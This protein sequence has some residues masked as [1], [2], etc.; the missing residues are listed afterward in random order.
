MVIGVPLPKA[1]TQCKFLDRFKSVDLALLMRRPDSA[2]YS[3]SGLIQETK[4]QHCGIVGIFAT[5]AIKN[6]HFL[7]SFTT[8]F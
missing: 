2:A 4:F 7:P 8:H 3:N 6:A 1:C 5:F